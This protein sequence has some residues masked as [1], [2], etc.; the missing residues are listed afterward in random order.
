MATKP[1]CFQSSFS[2]NHHHWKDRG[3]KHFQYILRV[4]W[5]IS[6]TTFQPTCYFLALLLS[7]R[8]STQFYH[9]EREFFGRL[10]RT[11][12]WIKNLWIWTSWAGHKPAANTKKK[13]MRKKGNV[14][15]ADSSDSRYS[16]WIGN[17]HDALFLLIARNGLKKEGKLILAAVERKCECRNAIRNWILFH[18]KLFQF[19]GGDNG[20][21]SVVMAFFSP[22]IYSVRKKAN[23]DE[24]TR[25]TQTKADKIMICG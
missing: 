16:E 12:R 10:E 13:T 4:I 14:L 25:G 20:R 18:H 5:H 23:M 22:H 3:I 2:G 17:G 21:F 8:S 24:R 7:Q 9:F 11:T 1:H 15:I 19:V 6:K